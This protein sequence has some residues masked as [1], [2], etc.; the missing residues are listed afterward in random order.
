MLSGFHY[1][2]TLA[3][4]DGRLDILG[5]I[6]ERF[7]CERLKSVVGLARMRGAAYAQV[8]ADHNYA[9]L[10]ARLDVSWSMNSI[11]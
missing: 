7:R 3:H 2:L 11:G 4:K 8:C 5:N 1:I 9:V 6:F 10:D